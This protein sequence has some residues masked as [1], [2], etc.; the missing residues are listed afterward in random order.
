MGTPVTDDNEGK[1]SKITWKIAFQNVGPKFVDAMFH[2]IVN[3]VR[4]SASADKTM[5]TLAAFFLLRQTALGRSNLV[6]CR[7]L[8]LPFFYTFAR[9]V[10]R[11]LMTDWCRRSTRIYVGRS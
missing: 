3:N 6:L 4:A 5:D 2:R 1:L 9:F 7:S 10:P 11:F 8:C